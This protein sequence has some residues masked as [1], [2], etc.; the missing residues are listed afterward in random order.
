MEYQFRLRS[1]F[2]K[3]AVIAL[4]PIHVGSSNDM[5]FSGYLGHYAHSNYVWYTRADRDDDPSK[6]RFASPARSQ[7]LEFAPCFRYAEAGCRPQTP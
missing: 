2:L 7:S 5:R 1:V 3:T 4:T 6:T